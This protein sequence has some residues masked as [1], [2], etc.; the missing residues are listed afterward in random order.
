MCG[1]L[2]VFLPFLTCEIEQELMGLPIA[3]VLCLKQLFSN[4]SQ[5]FCAAL[6]YHRTEKFQ[7]AE[8]ADSFYLH[9]LTNREAAQQSWDVFLY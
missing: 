2:G 7:L 1:V 9:V 4:P 5:F 6:M 3:S 8:G